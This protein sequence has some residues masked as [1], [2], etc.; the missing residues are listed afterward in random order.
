MLDIGS[1]DVPKMHLTDYIKVYDVHFPENFLEEILSEYHSMFVPAL[2]IGD[3]KTINEVNYNARVCELVSLSNNQM[4][5][6]RREI[7]QIISKE[8]T[9][10]LNLYNH[11]FP[12]MICREDRGYDL[13][14]YNIGGFH[15][16]HIDQ[17][18]S[19]VF[20]II[21]ISFILNDDYEGGEF[22]FFHKS[23]IPKVKKGQCIIF[24]SNFMYPHEITPV[25]KGT[26]YSI[27][28]WLY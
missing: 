4:N 27:I 20:R 16:E 11:E 10:I 17:H 15:V 28:T 14:K 21:G 26:R 23:Y 22:A 9:R 5:T 24:P 3:D 2:I 13:L 25:T 12:R 19:E 8:V 6:K 7:D 1:M 18:H